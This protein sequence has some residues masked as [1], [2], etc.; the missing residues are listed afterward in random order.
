[1]PKSLHHRRIGLRLYIDGSIENAGTEN[2]KCGT[3]INARMENAGTECSWSGIFQ[4][5]N[6]HPCIFVTYGPAFFCPTFFRSR[7]FSVPRIDFNL[8]KVLS[9]YAIRKAKE[10][11]LQTF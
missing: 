6:F 2:A 9:I 3:V 7:I 11:I 5:C 8:C 4:S 1:M 10:E